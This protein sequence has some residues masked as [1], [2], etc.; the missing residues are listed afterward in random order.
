[1]A[2]GKEANCDELDS[3]LALNL[4]TYNEESLVLHGASPEKERLYPQHPVFL[5][6]T[7]F[8]KKHFIKFVLEISIF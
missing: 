5:P 6:Y 7:L 4:S 8:Y 3:W 1:M 2:L